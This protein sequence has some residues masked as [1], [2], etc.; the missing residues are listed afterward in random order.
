[1]QEAGL[2]KTLD[3]SMNLRGAHIVRKLE[4]NQET[5]VTGTQEYYCEL[6]HAAE[7]SSDLLVWRVELA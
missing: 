6:T 3:G 2:L 4:S 1:M 7:P 5:S